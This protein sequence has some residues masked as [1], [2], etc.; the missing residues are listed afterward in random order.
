MLQ[1]QKIHYDSIDCS[2]DTFDNDEEHEND[3]DDQ[4]VLSRTSQEAE[5]AWTL[6]DWRRFLLVVGRPG[7]GKSYAIQQGLTLAFLPITMFLLLH[8]L[9]F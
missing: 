3:L 7:T 6:V 5:D 4:C 1:Q 2:F 8:P 9:G